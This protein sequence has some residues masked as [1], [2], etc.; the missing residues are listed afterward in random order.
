MHWA[1]TQ[2]TAAEIIHSRVDGSKPHAALTHFKG[3]EPTLAEAKTAK[4]FLYE[5]EITA[6]NHITSLTLE[7]F[8]SQAEQR[9]PV[10]LREFVSKMRD[11]I[12]L[13]G[14]PLIRE[15]DR[16]RVSMVDAQTKAN[17]EMFIYKQRRRQELE[18]QGEK[19][20]A[21]GPIPTEASLRS[22]E[23]AHQING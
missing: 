8:E 15:G 5:G 12:R 21:S 2:H 6:L 3:L 22:G 10:T 14:R 13:D 23:S 4:N 19:E 20:L 18:A 7:F 17:A 1:V 9:R 16:G 11:L